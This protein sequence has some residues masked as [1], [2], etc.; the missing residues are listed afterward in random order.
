MTPFFAFFTFLN[1]WWVMLFVAIP[2]SIRHE[3][4]DGEKIE[5][6]SYIA[7]PKAIYWKKVIAIATSLAAFITVALALVIKSGIVPVKNLY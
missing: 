1:A 5:G 7:A 2:F 3:N 6:E 4:K